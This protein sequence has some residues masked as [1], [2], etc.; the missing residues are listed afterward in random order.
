LGI[1]IQSNITLE[2]KADSELD[3][4]IPWKGRLEAAFLTAMKKL[5]DI[6]PGPLS[7]FLQLNIK[8]YRIPSLLLLIA[9]LLM[10]LYIKRYRYRIPYNA[11]VIA[12]VPEVLT[13]VS[14]F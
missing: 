4:K 11:C 3:I 6:T 2:E 8:R 14:I 7:T 1:C 12:V 5:R 9:C 10:M 13:V